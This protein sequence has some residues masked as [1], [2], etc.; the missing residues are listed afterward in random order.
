MDGLFDGKCSRVRSEM[1]GSL[2]NGV[3]VKEQPCKRGFGE[4]LRPLENVVCDLSLLRTRHLA[5][6]C[7][8][9]P[10]S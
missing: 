9:F 1:E 4:F 8:A 3:R 2:R 7:L 10:L 5:V 6:H